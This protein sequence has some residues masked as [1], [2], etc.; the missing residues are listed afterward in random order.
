MWSTPSCPCCD[1]SASL[2]FLCKSPKKEMK[3]RWGLKRLS[4]RVH[5]CFL[6]YVNGKPGFS[7]RAQSSVIYLRNRVSKQLFFFTRTVERSSWNRSAPSK[8][9]TF[10]DASI[11]HTPCL[12]VA[13]TAIY[14]I[15]HA[16]QETNSCV[17][18]LPNQAQHRGQISN[19]N[20]SSNLA[21]CL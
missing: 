14:I 1:P 6:S 8:K 15:L 20:V 9:V 13:V 5:V 11:F 16:Y 4:Q 2:S 18:T 12:H 19:L 10:H 17:A 3:Q 21:K 7:W